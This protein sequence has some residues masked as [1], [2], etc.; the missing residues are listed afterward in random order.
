MSLFE[1]QGILGNVCNSYWMLEWFAQVLDGTS[2][3]V[4]T[5]VC[6]AQANKVN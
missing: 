4:F 2:T 3:C 1:E 5:L 6:H